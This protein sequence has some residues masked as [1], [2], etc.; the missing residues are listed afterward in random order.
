MANP[1]IENGHLKIA[2][3]LV[4]A[5]ARTR[6]HNEASRVLFALLRLTYGWQ[7][8]EAEITLNQLVDLTC[9][10]KPNICRAVSELIKMNIITKKDGKKGA[11]YALQKNYDIWNRLKKGTGI[12]KRD[13]ETLSNEITKQPKPNNSKASHISVI[14]PDND[15]LLSNE[16]TVII[17]PDN[18]PLSNEI[19]PLLS[20]ERFKASLKKEP[21]IPPLKPA[22]KK[23]T[24]ENLTGLFPL[25]DK[26]SELKN[27]FQLTWNLMARE[28]GLTKVISIPKTRENKLRSRFQEEPFRQNIEKIF[29]EIKDSDFLLGQNDRNW[30]IDFDWL[31]ENDRNY[32]KVLEGKYKNKEAQYGRT[33]AKR[34]ILDP[35]SRAAFKRIDAKA[36][37]ELE[38]DIRDEAGGIKGKPAENGL[39]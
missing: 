18:K 24:K 4:E 8:K 33:G 26:F 12:I 25:L 34:N 11:I 2:N 28:K 13:N 23:I 15:K 1:Q 31:I 19:T 21:P 32:L 30:K 22:G 36:R 29:A 27:Q 5:F 37:Q 38:D 9:L 17:K 20:K 16:I 39:F 7:K 3:E 35:G 6:F 14:K 10:A